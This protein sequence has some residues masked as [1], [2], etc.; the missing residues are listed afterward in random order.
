[1]NEADILH[2]ELEGGPGPEAVATLIEY[3]PKPVLTTKER[4]LSIG[5]SL[6]VTLL[7]VGFGVGLG[8][9]FPNLIKN[10]LSVLLK[11]ARV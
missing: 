11:R 3:H 1:L 8:V 6:L 9:A 5:Y 2:Q 7:S 4:L 10:A